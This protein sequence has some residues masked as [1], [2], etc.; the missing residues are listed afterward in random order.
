[1][2]IIKVLKEFSFFV[3]SLGRIG[4][5]NHYG[6]ISSN[7][8]LNQLRKHSRIVNEKTILPNTT[9][10]K[11]NQQITNSIHSAESNIKLQTKDH[12]TFDEVLNCLFSLSSLK[13]IN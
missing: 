2:P 10:T 9:Q 5:N 7:I 12:V 8:T 13:L 11:L 6:T 3:V 4:S 1:M